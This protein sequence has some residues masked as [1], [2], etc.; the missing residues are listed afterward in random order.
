MVL[1]N[2]I[3]C[4]RICWI[5]SLDIK[6]NYK[7]VIKKAKKK[8][9]E[10]MSRSQN[11]MKAMWHLINE[12]GKAFKGGKKIELYSGTKIISDPQIVADML[13]NFFVEIINDLLSQNNKYDTN[14]QMQK[15]RIN[16][17]S[18]TVVGNSHS[19]K[20]MVSTPSVLHR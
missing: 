7:K 10:N 11:K 6:K 18:N 14:I 2:S 5:I 9:K 17:S 13:N 16:C 12:V 8:R 1:K 4:L 15:Q 3:I 19:A 20:Q